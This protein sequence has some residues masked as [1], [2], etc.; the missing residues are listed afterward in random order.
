VVCHNDTPALGVDPITFAKTAG[1][2]TTNDIVDDTITSADIPTDAITGTDILDTTITSTDILD[3]TITATDIL[4]GTTASTDVSDG[5]LGLVDM[6]QSVWTTTNAKGVLAARPAAAAGN[7]G[8]TYYATDVAGGALYR[9]DGATWSHV[10][11]GMPVVIP[12]VQGSQGAT[13]ATAAPAVWVNMPLALTELF[14]LSGATTNIA[15]RVQYDMSTVN[16][17]RLVLN[18]HGL[19]SAGTTAMCAQ[20]STDGGTTWT[21]LDNTLGTTC[22]GATVRGLNVKGV[23]ASAWITIPATAQADVQ[24]RIAGSGGNAVADPSFGYI[25]L[26][27]R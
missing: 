25:H 22:S 21:N 20:F 7:S 4:D 8:Y 10:G 5:S 1:A 2:I 15:H 23:K 11:T 12:F 9:S 6:A 13:T 26:Q 16:Q 18:S 19:G 27:V 24:L 17:A 14:N 3:G